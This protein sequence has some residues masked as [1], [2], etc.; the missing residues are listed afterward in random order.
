M[1]NLDAQTIISTFHHHVDS[2][3]NGEVFHQGTIV[4]VLK[5]ACRND[6]RY[7]QVLKVLTGRTTSKLLNRAQWYALHPPGRSG[8][9]GGR[10][11]GQRAWRRGS[12]CLVQYA[13]AVR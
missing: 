11:L 3:T 9:A 12:G 1:K 7:R 6:A 13:R 2:F 4:G 8:Q 10:S 5:K